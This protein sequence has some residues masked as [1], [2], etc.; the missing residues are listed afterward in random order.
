MA[1]LIRDAMVGCLYGYCVSAKKLNYESKEDWYHKKEKE[2]HV[3]WQASARL[4]IFHPSK[5]LD[6]LVPLS[7]CRCDWNW[8]IVDMACDFNY[9]GI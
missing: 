1:W 7:E 5:M 2:N 6:A 8:C 3:A 9:R 4:V